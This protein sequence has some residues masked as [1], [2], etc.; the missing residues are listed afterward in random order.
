MTPPAHERR[1]L[2]PADWRLFGTQLSEAHP[3]FTAFADTPPSPK[4]GYDMHYGLELGVVMSG[5]MQRRYQSYDH[6]LNPGGV[7]LSAMWEPHGW[8]VVASPCRH[9][10]IVFLPQ[11]ALLSRFGEAP[12]VDWLAPF[13][14]PPERRPTPSQS[15]QRETLAI[16]RS[17]ERSV[18]EVADPISLAKVIILQLLLVV[19]DGWSRSPRRRSRMAFDPSYYEA[20]NLSVEMALRSNRRVTEEEV[21]EK[22]GASPKVFEQAFKEIMRMPFSRFALRSR[23]GNAAAELID[24]ENG[25]EAVAAHWGFRSPGG[26]RDSFRRLFEAS[27]TD[28]RRRVRLQHA[29]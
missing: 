11:F 17:F 18:A 23:L 8:K 24:T 2:P 25:V 3:I 9:L 21:S 16:A 14:V 26:F 10:V 19:M 5:R 28:Y 12:D 27:P 20:V 4:S 13:T 29:R 1:V 6:E 15:K 22:I 7:W